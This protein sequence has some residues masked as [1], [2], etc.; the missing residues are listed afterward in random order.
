VPDSGYVSLRSERL[1]A[2]CGTPLESEKQK[3]PDGHLATGRVSHL[4]SLLRSQFWCAA[5]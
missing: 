3:K 2:W 1:S 4:E 5:L